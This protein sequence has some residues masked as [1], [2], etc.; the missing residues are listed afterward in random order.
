MR[1]LKIL[2]PLQVWEKV[3]IVVMFTLIAVTAV[4]GIG[5]GLG[6]NPNPQPWH[7]F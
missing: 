1:F 2:D 5:L 7:Y 6:S 3:F 4:L